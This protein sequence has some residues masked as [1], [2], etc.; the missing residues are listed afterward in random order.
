[1][2][3]EGYL[4]DLRRAEFY[5]GQI[6]HVERLAGQ[7]AKYGELCCALHPDLE[8][9]LCL[10]G[11]ER[12]YSHQAAA[13]QAA[14][15]AQHV[16]IV[17]ATSSGKT[18]CYNVP[19]L[20]TIL[21]QPN[22]RALYIFPTKALA[23]DQLGKLNAFGLFPQV[24]F[25]TYDGDTPMDERRAVRRSAQIVLTN[26]DMLHL[27]ILPGHSQWVRF[28]ANLRYIVLDEIHTYR[29]VFGGHVAHVLRRLRRLCRHYGAN[30]RFICCSATIA[31]PK[32]LTERLT[33]VKDPT[34]IE[35]NGAPQGRRSFVFWNPPLLDREIGVRASA[36]TE[37]TRLFCDL[38]SQGVR[39][40]VFTKARRSA[41]L[42]LHY[43]RDLLNEKAPH[44]V[45]RVAAYRAGY[46]LKERR[47][48]EEQLFSGQ[49]LGVTS[50][51]ALELGID[52]GGL[53]A[54]ILTGY[55]GTVAS[56]WQQAGRAGRNGEP[57]LNIL[58]AFDSPL[59][60]FLMNNPSYFFNKTYEHVVLNPENRRILRSHL[61]CAAYEQA[62]SQEDMELFGPAAQVCVQVLEEERQ[63]ARQEG[64]GQEQVRW[65]YNSSSGYPASQVNIRD[66]GGFP[67]RIEDMGGRLIGTMEAAT[68]FSALHPGAIY[69]HQGETYKVLELDVEARHAVVLATSTDY[70]TESIELT[71]LQVLSTK[72]FAEEGAFN[73]YF[74]EVVVTTQVVGFQR[75]RLYSDEVLSIEPLDLPEQTFETEAVWFTVPNALWQRLRERTC[76][77]AGSIHAL[78]HAVI[79]MM[80][81]LCTCDRWD[82]GGVSSVQH[83]QTFLPTVFIYDG[84]PG[85]IGIAEVAFQNLRVLLE[86]TRSLIA[87]CPCQEGCP[88]CVQSPK[89]GNNNQPLD[90]KGAFALL[91]LLLGEDKKGEE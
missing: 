68:A 20:Q 74:G 44:L 6:V 67:F 28:L 15:E 31:N 1:M 41:E 30:P 48:I 7:S 19:V 90:K 64:R 58:V 9:A 26:P 18:L 61:L 86:A 23:Q 4:Q 75:K 70:Y 50:T 55:P 17:T 82:I 11:I 46:T 29:G 87:K 80:P 12:F 73:A 56:T 81:L 76:D 36:H 71:H 47:A 53:Q 88:S 5:R 89:C 21:T 83:Q 27:G 8:R 37:A 38:V 63:L 35:E 39:T 10:Q 24:R 66:A 72:Q 42:I 40:I 22:V 79:G 13:I 25:A 84:H 33:G 45:E 3:F 65:F 32:E 34:L 62:L 52:V 85:G 14:L 77:L 54:S 60:Q 78:E 2:D 57:A 91:E 69:L 51:S 16:T 49:L 43:A 59:D